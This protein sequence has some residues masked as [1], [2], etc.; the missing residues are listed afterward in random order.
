MKLS[1]HARIRMQQRGIRP[2]VIDWL[3]AYGERVH[4]RGA[5]LFYFNKRGRMA[6]NKDLGRNALRGFSKNLNA[7][8]VCS[9]GTIVTVGHRYT[10]VV[11]H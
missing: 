6:L 2:I 9:E 5:E 10:R 4:Q 3:V 7:Y 11:R 1:N 8:L